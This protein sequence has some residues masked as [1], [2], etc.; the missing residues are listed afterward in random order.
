MK[1]KRTFLGVGIAFFV[2]IFM[3]VTFPNPN[4]SNSGY[5][6]PADSGHDYLNHMPYCS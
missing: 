1:N 6:M 3:A 5:K 2:V 4:N